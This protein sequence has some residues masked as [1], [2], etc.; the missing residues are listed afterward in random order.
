MWLFRNSTLHFFGVVVV[1]SDFHSVYHWLQSLPGRAQA[2]CIQFL[3][4]ALIFFH[5]NNNASYLVTSSAPLLERRN[6]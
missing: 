4:M 2:S 3:L 5:G 1:P 6:N